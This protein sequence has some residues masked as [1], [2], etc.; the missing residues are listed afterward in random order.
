MHLGSYIVMALASGMGESDMYMYDYSLT[1][2]L[3]LQSTER[4]YRN[5]GETVDKYGLIWGS[6]PDA[7]EV[8]EAQ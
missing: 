5:N 4:R 1:N 3:T 8:Y 6:Y 2:V 7:F